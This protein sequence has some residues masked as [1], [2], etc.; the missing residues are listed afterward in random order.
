MRGEIMS[1]DEMAAQI[2]TPEYVQAKVASCEHGIATG[3]LIVWIS[4][5]VL[6]ICA[7]ACIVAY[8]LEEKTRF[9]PWVIYMV[10]ALAAIIGAL[11]L[12]GGIATIA[13]CSSD[14][15]W[16]QSDPVTK[17]VRMFANAL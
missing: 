9:D 6:A 11:A 2:A 17:V 1:I 3:E 5:G 7:I 16:W 8:A 10:C 13:G 12:I 15:V 14:L 4:L